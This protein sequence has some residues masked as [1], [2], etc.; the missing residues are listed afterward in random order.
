MLRIISP[1]VLSLLAC[2]SAQT[3]Q[4]TEPSLQDIRDAIA[5]VEPSSPVSNVR[6]LAFDRFYQIWL[7]NIV[8]LLLAS[9]C[10]G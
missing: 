8:R 10:F 5:A 1:I 6:G 9:F 2:A 7:E 3:I 4:G